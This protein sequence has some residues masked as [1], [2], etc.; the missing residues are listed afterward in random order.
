MC[1]RYLVRLLNFMKEKG[2]AVATP[3]CDRNRVQLRPL[4]N[5]SSGYLQRARDF[6]PQAAGKKP[7]KM[8]DNFFVDWMNFKTDSVKEDMVFSPEH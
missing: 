1:A 6:M 5:L 2:Y 7:W 3:T 4:V 8:R